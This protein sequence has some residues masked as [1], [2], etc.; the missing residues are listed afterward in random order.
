MP[1]DRPYVQFDE[2]APSSDDATLPPS[3]S[4]SLDCLSMYKCL[5]VGCVGDM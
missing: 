2:V 4:S 1:Q 5:T 3:V